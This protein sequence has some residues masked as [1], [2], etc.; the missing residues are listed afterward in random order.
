ME[1]R[2]SAKWPDR[3]RRAA[4]DRPDRTA[5][6][7]A[8]GTESAAK[9]MDSQ[10][11]NILRLIARKGDVEGAL[12][13]VCD[14]VCERLA[15]ACAAIRLLEEGGK[16]L[17]LAAASGLPPNYDGISAIMEVGPEAGVCGRAAWGDV[18]VVAENVT[19]S[20]I[21]NGR[22]DIATTHGIHACW[23]Y[24][25]RRTSGRVSG[26]ISIYLDA[27][28]APDEAEQ[29]ILHEYADL[30]SV[31]MELYLAQAERHE[32]AERM[33]SLTANLPGMLFQWQADEAGQFTFSF[34][35]EGAARLLGLPADALAATPAL[36]LDRLDPDQRTALHDM[37]ARS[38]ETLDPVEGDI[39]YPH[40]QDGDK[41]LLVRSRPRRLAD[42]G[43]IS[44]ALALDISEHKEAEL[45]LEK[46]QRDMNAH[47]IELE[48][49]RTRQEAQSDVLMETARELTAA[50]DEAEA[51]SEAK[52][53][54]LSNMSHE[55]RTPLNAIIGFSEMIKEQTFGPIGSPKYRDYA[56]EIYESG[57]HLLELI[58]EILDLAKA[59][60]GRDTLK[61]EVFGID[62]LVDST[63]HIARSRAER[64]GVTLTADLP[65]DM[66]RIR[67]DQRKMRQ[68]LLNLVTNAIK[69][70]GEGGEVTITCWARPASGIVIQVIDNGIGIAME[71]I[72]KA[73]GLF[74]QID[75]AFSRKHEGTGLGLPLSKSLVEQHSGSLDLQSKPGLGTTV[76]VRL[77]PNRIVE[78]DDVP[79]IAQAG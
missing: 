69:F 50:R 28:C 37:F 46:S 64:E 68:V 51:A 42:G 55:L 14:A 52:S 41:W 16:R 61:E 40:P 3:A 17:R 27:P 5:Q 25:I 33:L 36:F 47:L 77:P 66:P 6:R 10:L 58:N 63:I 59:E 11:A 75:N 24:P 13:A 9:V 45:S 7:T 79:E 39:R 18:M 32:S 78:A 73:L 26:T 67:A 2:P 35:S 60:S 1:I 21:W 29:A 31:A 65:N 54:F 23:A 48:R 15:G 43:I 20:P 71:D 74:G 72:P 44:D 22:P 8:T 19:T 12:E 4:S 76:T 57:R 62:E 53:Q 38:M 34:V 56:P 49:A 70:T 30:A